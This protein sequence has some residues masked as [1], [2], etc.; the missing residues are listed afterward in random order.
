M[1]PRY[2]PQGV[3]ERWQRTWEEEGLYNA[4]PRSRPGVVRDLHPSAQRDRRVAHGPRSERVDPGPAHSPA[5]DARLQHDLAARLRPRRDRDAERDREGA[6]EGRPDAARPRPRGLRR[7]HLGLAREVRRRDHGAATAARRVA[8]LPAR[9][10]DDGRGLRAGGAEVVRAPARARIPLPGQPDRQLVPAL[11]ERDLRSRGEPRG[12]RR[13]AVHDPLS[14]GRR[15]RAHQDCDSA[16]AD[17]ARRRRRRRA[18]GRR[19]LPRPGRQGGRA[20][21]RRPEAA[22]H[23]GRARRPRVRHRRGEDHARSRPD[24]L[25]DRPRPRV[26]RTD[27]DRPR[28]AHERRGRGVRRADSGGGE[29]AASSRVWRARACSS[30]RSPTGTPSRPAT[31]ADRESSRS[32]RSS[33]GAT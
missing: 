17:D 21:D 19:P 12:D 31:A 5:P 32:S 8:R 3:E 15:L 4:E 27:G 26:G 30:R 22:D 13:H 20:S 6:R 7:A 23:R 18:P 29:R 14:A 33:G 1:E 2:E 10:D 9:A 11:R 25:G 28:R 24:G 16:S